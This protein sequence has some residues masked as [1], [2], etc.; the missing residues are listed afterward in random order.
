MPNGT[1][2]VAK[3]F[4]G[5]GAGPAL[6]QQAAARGRLD[7]MRMALDDAQ[8][9]NTGN[10]AALKQIKLDAL[11]PAT[12]AASFAGAGVPQ[13]HAAGAAGLDRAGN[14][15]SQIGALMKTLQ[16]QAI[17]RD[18]RDAAVRG[19]LNGANANLFGLADK[20]VTLSQVTDGVALNPTVTPDVNAF[21][22]TAV[23]QSMIAQRDA[24]ATN[25]MAGAGANNALRDLRDVQTAAG[26]F[27]PRRGTAAGAA[28][29]PSIA[30]VRGI[31]PATGPANAQG[32]PTTDPADVAGVMSW[33]ADHPGSTIGDYVNQAPV[34]SAGAMPPRGADTLPG[35]STAAMPGDDSADDGAPAITPAAVSQALA[36][37]AP[38]GSGPVPAA[39]TKAVM[40]AVASKAADTSA[41]KQP[42]TQAEFDALPSGT[43]FINPADG[44]LMR[45][46]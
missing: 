21:T 19:D 39:A 34:G 3:F 28:K 4:A 5:L 7:A 25:S 35:L 12:L 46:K 17:A 1:E 16:E 40:D 45:K 10:D 44:R 15:A 38:P 13:E 14:N 26:G 29:L 41:P 18:A 24:A 30:T 22:P 6:R 2:G 27:N 43:M 31:L 11:D 32:N 8:I 42:A 33:L 20:P 37:A 36:A 9:R 23:G